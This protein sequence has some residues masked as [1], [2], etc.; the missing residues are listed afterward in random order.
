M[1]KYLIPVW[2]TL[3]LLL[4]GPALANHCD[5]QYAA[6]QTTVENTTDIEPNTLEAA[7]ALLSA[8]LAA[9]RQE[10]EQMATAIPD[11]PLLA[12][13]HVSVGQSMLINVSQLL[14]GH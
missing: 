11:S 9:C 6:V 10:E 4:A 7:T 2:T 14:S 5:P 12:A 13:D 3:A 8:G 1:T